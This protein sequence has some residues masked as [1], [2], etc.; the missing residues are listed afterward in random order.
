M[1]GIQ[2]R[3]ALWTGVF[4]SHQHVNDLGSPGS[5]LIEQKYIEGE[6]SL[7]QNPEEP[8]HD[9]SPEQSKPTWRLKSN[10]WK[11]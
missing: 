1:W 5:Q 3:A 9:A 8:P 4:G 2:K 11:K 7:P 10:H 6:E